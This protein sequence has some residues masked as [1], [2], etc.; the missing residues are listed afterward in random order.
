MNG[1]MPPAIGTRLKDFR[2]SFA[3]SVVF[4]GSAPRKLEQFIGQRRNG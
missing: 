4:Q 3:Q 1:L 2:K